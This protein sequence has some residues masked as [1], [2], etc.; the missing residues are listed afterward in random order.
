VLLT[1]GQLCCSSGVPGTPDAP[2]DVIALAAANARLRAANG[3]LRALLEER[4]ARIAVLE[5]QVAELSG[6]VARLER[7]ASRNSGNSSL[8]PSS[9]DQPGKKQPAQPGRRTD[10]KRKPGK[11]PGAPGAHLAWSEN[12]RTPD[13]GRSFMQGLGGI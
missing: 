6:R 1:E 13:I 4:D 12:P 3:K 11:Q 8:P 9:D 5:A 7:Q 10:G 2:A